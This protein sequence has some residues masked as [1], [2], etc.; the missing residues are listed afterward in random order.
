MG[1]VVMDFALL[2]C[3]IWKQMGRQGK[4]KL[5]DDV[6]QPLERNG[7]NYATRVYSEINRCQQSR[8]ISQ[9]FSGEK[10][11]LQIINPDPTN[12]SAPQYELHFAIFSAFPHFL[13]F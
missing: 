9:Y 2:S 10:V 6:C 1:G 3:W 12:A 8:A 4:R 11:Q 13:Q 5:S 7:A